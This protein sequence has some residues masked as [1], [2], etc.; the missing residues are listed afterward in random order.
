MIHS[1]AVFDANF[2]DVNSA[3]LQFFCKV[4]KNEKSIVQ[5]ALVNF[6]VSSQSLQTTHQSPPLFR[7]SKPFLGLLPVPSDYTPVTTFYYTVFY[8]HLTHKRR[9]AGVK[10]KREGNK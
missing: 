3:F 1:Y 7:L 4:S 6:C 2:N 10:V 8:S 9:Q 5:K